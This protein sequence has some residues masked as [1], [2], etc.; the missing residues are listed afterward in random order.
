MHLDK[1]DKIKIEPSDNSGFFIHVFDVYSY[2][3]LH[4]FVPLLLLGVAVVTQSMTLEKSR[5]AYLERYRLSLQSLGETVA[6][7]VSTTFHSIDAGLSSA[8]EQLNLR[9]RM[10]E[11]KK[12][13]LNVDP[14]KLLDW[15]PALFSLRVVDSDGLVLY[16]NRYDPRTRVNVG[17]RTFF[18]KLKAAPAAGMVINEPVFGRIV[19]VWI[20]MC[21]RRINLPDG[22]FGGV[23]YGSL[24]LGGVTKTLFG[25]NTPA[26][27][28]TTL[29]LL[30]DS[31]HVIARYIRGKQDTSVIGKKMELP[32]PKDITLSETNADGYLFTAKPLGEKRIGYT[33]HLG[34]Y[35]ISVVVSI[36]EDDALIGWRNEARNTWIA[37]AVFFVTI[38]IASFIMYKLQ[39][40]KLRAVADL[41]DA[42]AL[43]EEIVN[44]SSLGIQ[45]YEERGQ[46]MLANRALAEITEYDLKDIMAQNLQGKCECGRELEAFAEAFVIGR[47]VLAGG[48]A[49]KVQGQINTLSGRK[50]WL[51]WIFTPLRK[52]GSRHLLVM[53]QDITETQ[54]ARAAMEEANRVLTT[55]SL[56]DGLT[57]IANRR[58]FD[59]TLKEEWQRAMR[60]RQ[61][62]SLAL[63]DVDNFKNYNDFY[64]HQLGDVC[65]K[66]VAKAIS[67]QCRRA[68]DVVARYG[69]EEFAV[70]CSNCHADEIH[71]LAEN[72]RAAV[73]K[74]NLPH[75][76]SVYGHVT[77]S[78]GVVTVVPHLGE[79]VESFIQK[80][81]AALYMV[82]DHG[83]NAV[84]RIASVVPDTTSH[85][86]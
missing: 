72:M 29:T 31:N 78:I 55:M 65:L 6:G 86:G 76:K 32:D 21:G 30:D 15:S 14:T 61:S 35:P 4:V 83:R 64:G 24:D 70:V 16:G 80:A 75:E 43:N 66:E 85:Q 33:Q 13:P 45:V 53:T 41:A 59:A 10:A 1:T 34:N 44:N 26:S 57:E 58:Q 22:S 40:R 25:K 47:E 73:E 77:V 56:T 38:S 84:G 9:R 39:M 48:E 51:E 74:L 71:R 20:L 52:Q 62:I 5:A 79:T 67:G 27:S 46:C 12:T 36:S 49:R 54:E 2:R 50:V 37:M 23:I 7:S 42:L 63:M 8:N 81:D 68:G 17:D 69:G 28:R 19:P 18:K 60:N 82:K 3:F 11:L